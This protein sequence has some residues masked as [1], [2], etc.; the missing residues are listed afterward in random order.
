MDERT[1]ENL[2]RVDWG[3]EELRGGRFVRCTFFDATLEELTTSG[4][5]FEDCDLSGVSLNASVHEDSAFLRCRFRKASLFGATLRGCKL[6]GSVFESS[7][8]RPL[9]VE[10]GDWSY[11]SLRGQ[12]LAG[13]GL[14][15]VRLRE[16]DLSDADLTGA[17]LT[18]AD[19]GHVRLHGV[20]LRGA[21]LRG[22][23]LEG[24]DLRGIDLTGVRLDVTQAVRLA[25]SYGAEVDWA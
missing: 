1:D 3:G 6:T 23:A 16:A 24:V 2:A 4:C 8:L 11:V 21:D 5:V 19:L 13:V 20:R 22:A 14:A 9:T 25:V 12:S 18:G 17:D 10:G 15:G 7:V